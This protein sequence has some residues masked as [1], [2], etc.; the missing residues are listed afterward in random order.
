MVCNKTFTIKWNLFS[1]C[2]NEK[3]N[4]YIG[5]MMGTA[6]ITGFQRKNHTIMLMTIYTVGLHITQ[7]QQQLSDTIVE[8]VLE[9]YKNTRQRVISIHYHERAKVATASCNQAAA[10]AP[11]AAFMEL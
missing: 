11:D 5:I 1:F 7:I 10:P 8:N 6:Y 2:I 9:I 3:C 4:R